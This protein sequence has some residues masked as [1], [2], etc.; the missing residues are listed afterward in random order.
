M[1]WT[2]TTLTLLNSAYIPLDV[3]SQLDEAVTSAVRHLKDKV[4]QRAAHVLNGM[5]GRD[6]SRLTSSGSFLVKLLHAQ[7]S[8]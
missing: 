1:C 7:G 5:N 6:S 4:V 8:S 2:R 3:R